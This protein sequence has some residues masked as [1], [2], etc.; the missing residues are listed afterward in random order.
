M[1]MSL[2]F[3]RIL[4]KW[5]SRKYSFGYRN[6]FS[7]LMPSAVVT[8]HII[9]L[10]SL[11]PTDDGQAISSHDGRN[12]IVYRSAP[13]YAHITAP[14]Q[15]AL[16][17]SKPV[18][19]ALDD[20]GAV[21]DALLP[22]QA[23]TVSIKEDAQNPG[24]EIVSFE[25]MAGRYRLDKNDPAAESIRDCLQKSIDTKKSIWFVYDVKQGKLVAAS[26]AD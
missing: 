10:R 12:L 23:K 3:Q 14:L 2:V 18:A 21:V 11:T 25:N 15:S 20:K 1:R 4:E 22:Q 16:K 26:S 9:A 24:V 19:V 6:T 7:R 5:G 8:F 13:N 17:Q